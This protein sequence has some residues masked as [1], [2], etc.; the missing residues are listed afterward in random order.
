MVK[1]TD[2]L[3]YVCI[4]CINNLTNKEECENNCKSYKCLFCNTKFYFKG[5]NKFLGHDPSCYK[6]KNI[7]I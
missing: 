1:I 3:E 6:I 2:Y 4:K 7:P 5:G